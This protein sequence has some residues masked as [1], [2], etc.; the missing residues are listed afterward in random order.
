[1]GGEKPQPVAEEIKSEE[2]LIDPNGEIWG[3]FL[4]EM[5]LVTRTVKLARPADFAFPTVLVGR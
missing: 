4:P 2:P 1:M 3:R 5:D